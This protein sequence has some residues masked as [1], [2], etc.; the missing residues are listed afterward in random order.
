MRILMTLQG[1]AVAPRF[2]L[3]TEILLARAE[4]G[5]LVEPPREI[6]LP[7]P[8]GEELCGLVIKEG[9]T[10]LICGGIEEEHYQYLVWKGVEVLDRVIGTGPLALRLALDGK[11][12]A[13]SVLRD[14]VKERGK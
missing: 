11:L 10:H 3:A 9:I 7:G 12:Q 8:S 14:K 1:E 5:E 4:R 13:G 2:D 6:L